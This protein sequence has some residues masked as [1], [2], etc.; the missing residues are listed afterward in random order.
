MK[1]I[2]PFIVLLQALTLSITQAADN[3]EEST[4]NVKESSSSNYLSA[5]F[6]GQI[7]AIIALV[8]CSGIVAGL[9]LGLMSQDVTNLAILSA[10]GTPKQRKYAAR[11]MPI[12]K[13]GHLV[14][15]AL[16]LTNTVL[17]ET[18]PVLID[19]LFGQG[20]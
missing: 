12:R 18:L 3:L 13:N 15:T 10:A 16:L 2:F 1:N 8:V 20:K 11:I 14:L 6:W 5:Q 4:A 7:I 17:N 19:G 9:T